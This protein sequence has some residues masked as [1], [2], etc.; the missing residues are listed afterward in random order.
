MSDSV[1]ICYSCGK[2]AKHSIMLAITGDRLYLPNEIVRKSEPPHPG[3]GPQSFCITCMRAI[4]DSLRAT[5][6]YLQSESKL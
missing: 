6:Q 2:P 4:E 5:V 1:E 3:Y